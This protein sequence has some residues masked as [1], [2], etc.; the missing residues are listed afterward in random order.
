MCSCQ[1]CCRQGVGSDKGTFKDALRFVCTGERDVVS[2]THAC[3]LSHDTVT[4]PGFVRA[5]TGSQ[6]QQM[7][8]SSQLPRWRTCTRQSAANQGA[9]NM[10]SGIED[11]SSVAEKGSVLRSPARFCRHLGSCSAVKLRQHLTL[12]RRPASCAAC[13]SFRG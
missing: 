5:G 11:S 6:L 4:N 9:T 10:W 2:Q 13:I 3:V 1:H 12:Q 7:T 8:R